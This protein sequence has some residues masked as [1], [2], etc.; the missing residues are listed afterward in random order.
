V[1]GRI[2]VVA[3]LLSGATLLIGAFALVLTLDR[4]LTAGDD[5]LARARLRDLAALAG[6][7]RLPPSVDAG[8]GVAQVVDG[9]G[10]VLASSPNVAGRPRIAGFTTAGGGP[11]VRT[12]VGPDD[13]DIETYRLWGLGA[14]SPTGPVTVYVGTS[15]ESVREATAALRRALYVALPLATLLLAGGT[16]V[17][18]GRT[19]RPVEAIRAEV[20]SITEQRLDHRVPVPSGTDEIAR[21]ARTMNAMLDRL[22]TSADRQRRFVADASHELQSPLAALRAELEVAQ[23]GDGG[24]TW[25]ETA[26]SLLATTAE[27]EALV[28]DLLYLARTE[29]PEGQAAAVLV[30]L[31][32]IVLEEVTRV[33]ATTTVAFDLT[34]VSAAPALG[35]PGELRRLVRNLLEN[36][37]QH[38]ASRVTVAVACAGG[39]A[40]VDVCDDGPGVP[41][42][43]R[44]RIFD[45]FYRADASRSRGSGG[46][47]LG[48][49]I[50]HAIAAGHGGGLDLEASARGAHFSLWLPTA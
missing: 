33:R 50:A 21:L 49:A 19:L 15:T 7:G 1:R 13:A 43:H 8:D 6:E 20:A 17:V 24:R 39:R 25:H 37:A 22:E 16:W 48:L 42:E 3:T 2:T 36:A 47:G 35:V 32:D 23:A 26:D 18:T 28:R 40:A 29:H 44:D 45:R 12:V 31:D 30:D 10:R 11:R 34:A 41:P 14:A 4:S 46:T 9:T 27:M 38:A 5:A